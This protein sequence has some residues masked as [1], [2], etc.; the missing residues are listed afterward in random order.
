MREAVCWPAYYSWWRRLLETLLL[1][2][3]L[4][5]V[6]PWEALGG[7]EVLRGR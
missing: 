5:I 1:G 7:G 6:A 4:A 3:L 2:G